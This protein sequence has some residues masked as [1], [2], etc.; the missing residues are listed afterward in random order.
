MGLANCFRR[1]EKR[2]AYGHALKY[3]MSYI[4]VKQNLFHKG[5]FALAFSTYVHELCH[6]FGGDASS[7]Y[8]RALSDLLMIQLLKMDDIAKFSA[9]WDAL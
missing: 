8:S 5:L 1:K 3:T 2:N 9:S 4:A 7:N 6:V